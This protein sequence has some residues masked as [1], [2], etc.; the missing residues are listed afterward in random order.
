MQFSICSSPINSERLKVNMNREKQLKLIEIYRAVRN[1]S[2]YTHQSL[3]TVDSPKSNK[4]PD[5]P[6]E[7][8]VFYQTNSYSGFNFD[9]APSN[10]IGQKAIGNDLNLFMQGQ[11]A[12]SNDS[13]LRKI[14]KC[15]EKMDL[16]H[17]DCVLH[18]KLN[19]QFENFDL[20]FLFESDHTKRHVKLSQTIAK[21]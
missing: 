15:A 7:Y 18:K 10:K 21:A 12:Y 17:F 8:T 5:A 14:V 20:S 19:S 3:N 11:I 9:V 6:R 4:F 13:K 1:Y 2:Q 16:K